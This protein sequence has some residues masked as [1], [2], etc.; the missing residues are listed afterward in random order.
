MKKFRF[1]SLILV[2]SLLIAVFSSCD[3][4][5]LI[6]EIPTSGI[7]DGTSPEES[8]SMSEK[9]YSPPSNTEKE[10]AGGATEGEL[11]EIST[12][13]ATTE[14]ESYT[15]Q[16]SES[17]T[18][19]DPKYASYI[20]HYDVVYAAH[21]NGAI[22]LHAF[23]SEDKD[24]SVANWTAL[25]RIAVSQDG[26]WSKVIY[27]DILYYVATQCVTTLSDPDEGFTSV[28]K[29]LYLKKDISA[30]SV[31]LLPDMDSLVIG[32]VYS[33]EKIHVVAENVEAGW[34]KI[35]FVLYGGE[36]SFG[37]ITS[38]P[39]YFEEEYVSE[40]TTLP[41]EESSEPIILPEEETT[42]PIT[43]PE[44]E[45]TEPIILPED[46]TDGHTYPESGA[47]AT[48]LVCGFVRAHDCFY[49]HDG[50][51]MCDACQGKGQSYTEPHDCYENIVYLGIVD[52]TCT[53]GGYAESTYC[54][55]CGYIF[56]SEMNQLTLPLGHDYNDELECQ[57]CGVIARYT[58][59]L[60]F[61]LINDGT[62]YEVYDLADLS[63]TE[64]IIPAY[65]NGL[66][67]TRID[68]NA[69][70]G[71]GIGSVFIPSTVKEIGACAFANCTNLRIIKISEGVEVIGAAAFQYCTSLNEV[72][73]PSTVSS[74][75]S[76]IFSDC[77]SLMSVNIPEGIKSI[78]SYAFS[79]C[80]S[81]REIKFPDSLEEIEYYAF[82]YSSL[83]SISIPDSVKVIGNEAFAGCS[84]LTGVTLGS[85]TMLEDMSHYAFKDCANLVYNQLGDVYY[86]G[87]EEQ[88]YL[89]LV[90]AK[91]Q[92]IRECSV[93]EHTKYI[94]NYAFTECRS[95]R[96]LSITGSVEKIGCHA[97]ESCT[98]LTEVSIPH[99]VKYID[100]YAFNGCSGITSITLSDSIV[101]I[102]LGAFQGC[103]GLE[104][105]TLPFVGAQN[106]PE[107]TAE[108][109]TNEASEENS[110]EATEK[111]TYFAYIFGTSSY[112]HYE[113]YIPTTL[114]SVTVTGGS[115]IADNAFYRCGNITSI[116]LPNGIQSI[117]EFAFSDCYALAEL[118]IPDSV[119][120]IG[121]YAFYD[122][123]ALTELT[124]PDSV[125]SIGEYAFYNCTG[126]V[127]VKLPDGIKSISA[128]T[129]E[130]CSNLTS[131]E[132]PKSVED[133]GEYAFYACTLLTS[134]SVP[135]SVKS[136][137][138]GAFFCCSSLE[139]I[140]LP[141]VGAQN[142]TDAVIEQDTEEGSESDNV[143]E[144]V[145]PKYTYFAY[146]FGS[147]THETYNSEYVPASLLN[148]VITGGESIDDN[149]FY[150]CSN[151]VSITLPDTI[152]SIGEY[153]FYYCSSLTDIIIPDSVREIGYN[154][155]GYCSSLTDIIIPDSVREIG[156][157]AFVSCSSLER[158][159]LP[160]IG[161]TH[162][163]TFRPHFSS[164][165]GADG[166]DYQGYYDDYVPSSLQTVV[167]TNMETIPDKA[168]YNCFNITSITLPDTVTEFGSCAFY[169]CSALSSLTIPSS[170]TSIGNEALTGCSSL[171]Y[172]EENGGRYLGN[173]QNPYTILMGVLDLSITSFEIPQSVACIGDGAFRDCIALESIVIPE[174][175]GS[176][177]K[178]AFSNCSALVNVTL[179]D[180]LKSIGEYA[181]YGCKVL[182]SIT[183]PDGLERIYSYAFQ[184]C[185]SLKGIVVPDSVKTISPGAF[186]G[187]TGLESITIPF[188]GYEK[189]HDENSMNF[190]HIFGANGCTESMYVPSTLKT[191]IITGGEVI[192]DHAF[193][194]CA[195]I[196]TII[197][198]ESIKSIGYSSFSNCTSLKSLIIPDGVE[199]IDH[200]A[201]QSCYVIES[202]VIPASV[203]SI[204]DG[205]F[206]YCYALTDIT[207]MG[208]VEQWNAIPKGEEWDISSDS[209]T[210]ICTDGEITR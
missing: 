31:R 171:V 162:G 120:S 7:L 68:A 157:N 118:T 166:Y 143:N 77:S 109:N 26:E 153:A 148:V 178:D 115:Y 192:Y 132:I 52:A 76:N 142:Y 133:I 8:L 14:Q 44:E 119:T 40:E 73:L 61:D 30:L 122:C 64:I 202:I 124:I 158:I 176:I 13:E 39:K 154:A 60:S 208:T 113:N 17:A 204:G 85:G 145:A 10:T 199:L 90:K 78:P 127:S 189:A 69:F 159:T 193:Y 164:L 131:V 28:D 179:P 183:L 38:D 110:E 75:G 67:V 92:K 88:P 151:I 20:E 144:E 203:N 12:E 123:Y 188:V 80:Y 36:K 86:L 150:Y 65:Y 102:G 51:G 206:G 100:E 66:P 47:W 111:Y 170:L 63:V 175:V 185:T 180:S 181:F 184:N 32:Y 147:S 34:Y 97:F 182:E 196:E 42:E 190:A 62:E 117:G 41:E 205:A 129:F 128:R 15:E 50:D 108:E 194:A 43:L 59:S 24:T 209:Y 55:L 82:A 168:F 112:D 106:Y 197:L 146:I 4:S 173:E 94:S 165:F 6:N 58:D 198:P 126:L 53:E 11:T 54:A 96:S 155:F 91:N 27:K 2:I 152:E 125:A 22:M 167:I 172:T 210:V 169:N 84:S 33:G 71:Y 191:V 149:A 3:L 107:E 161:T 9:P 105:I 19:D 200:Y 160:I 174:G 23:L 70:E 5:G 130:C 99:G 139:S 207:Y 116:T 87:N 135:D 114:R 18:E 83:S 72:R 25:Q 1:L 134:I 45:T 35:S 21:P 29:A 201:F 89:I 195:N 57:S 137:G 101:S 121:G 103:S 48:C 141:F 37:Y 98:S 93:S 16:E 46:C 163:D 56:S 136:I 186:N 156:Y 79:W 138:F 187:C 74:M 177:G 95:L 104:S 81:L 140:T 49:D